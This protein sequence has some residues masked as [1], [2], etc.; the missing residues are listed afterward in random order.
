MLRVLRMRG[1][2]MKKTNARIVAVFGIVTVLGG[3]SAPLG[4]LA[5]EG[6]TPPEGQQTPRAAPASTP[7]AAPPTPAPA[8]S[9]GTSVPTLASPPPQSKLVS[10]SG[11][12]MQPPYLALRFGVALVGAMT[13][14]VVWIMPGE[15]SRQNAQAVW[16]KTVKNYWGWPEFVGALSAPKRSE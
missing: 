3:M 6:S 11:L 5:Q 4:V 8:E 2:R 1:R 14:G 9:T 10:I 16:E 12:V 13:S 7:D 15:N